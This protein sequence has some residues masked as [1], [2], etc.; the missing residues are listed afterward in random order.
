MT[1]LRLHIEQAENGIVIA[2]R[3]EC[4]TDEHYADN[5]IVALD[6][7]KCYELGKYIWEEVKHVMDKELVNAVEMKMI[8]Q[9]T[10]MRL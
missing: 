3:T 10:N 6:K 9:E 4:N 2:D 8:I 5:I 1:Q 7:G